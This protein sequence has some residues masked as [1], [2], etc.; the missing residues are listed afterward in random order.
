MKNNIFVANNERCKLK[1]EEIREIM[2]KYGEVKSLNLRFHPNN[3]RNEAMI[4]FSTEEEAQLAITEI[5]TYVRWR[6]ELYKPTKKSREFERATKKPDNN[7]KEQKQRKNNENSTKQVE[8]SYLKEE[9]KD[10]KKNTRHTTEKT[11]TRDTKR[12]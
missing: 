11:M 8:L 12:Q 6:V 7:N 4:S 3:T 1:E 9:I 2:E 5:N 10:I